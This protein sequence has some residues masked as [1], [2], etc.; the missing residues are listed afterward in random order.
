MRKGK[1][2]LWLLLLSALL[3][4]G[5]CGRQEEVDGS[6]AV[7]YA[8]AGSS[9][10]VL[11]NER[12]RLTLEENYSVMTIVDKNTGEKWSS[13]PTD[14]YFDAEA[15]NP[16][17]RMRTSSLFQLGYTNIA[18]GL[19][20][21]M[22]SPLLQMDY[23]AAGCLKDGQLYVS[24]D[25]VQPSIRM[26]LAFSL[27]E[28]GFRVRVPFDGIEEYGTQFSVVSLAVLPYMSGATDEAEGYYLYPDGSGAVME[29]QD[30]AHIG[31]SSRS[32][33]LY[34]D[35][36]DYDC[37]RLPFESETARA[38]LPVYGVNINDRGY[39]AI[40][41]Q[42][43]TDARI[44][45]SCSTK[46]VAING[47]YGEFLYRRGFADAR[48]KTSTVLSYAGGIIPGDREIYY[49]FLETGN[50]D[51]SAMAASYRG[52]L[53]SQGM[54]YGAEQVDY[55]LFLDILMG[56]EAEGLLFDEWRQ[57]TDFEQAAQMAT[58]LKEQGVENLLINLKGYTKHGYYSE[59]NSFRINSSLG[60]RA[61][62]KR[63]LKTAGELEVPVTLDYHMLYARKR[64]GGFSTQKD[65][66]YLG[67]YVALTDEE[68]ELYLLGPK[69]ALDKFGK[70]DG[71]AGEY[72]TAGY[73]LGGIGDTLAY[74][75]NTRSRSGAAET[76]AQWK[77]LLGGL[78]D[79]GRILTVEG[80]NAYV[81][82]YAD[83]LKDIPDRDLGF[84]FTTRSV[85]F[86]QLVVHGLAG[87][88]TEAGN[89]SGDLAGEKLKWVEYGYI[90]YFELT[91]EGS[92]DL[93]YTD[94]NELFTSEY[95][96]W[97]D[98]AV[99][100]Y[101]E[102]SES[103]GFLAGEVMEEHISLGKELYRVTYGDGTR[104]Y[105][106]YADFEQTA[107]GVTVPAGDYA[108]ITDSVER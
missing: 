43:D 9:D 67:N 78:S 77:E 12:Y 68:E 86:F 45:V 63:F 104:V 50:T 17:W 4:L 27:E 57:V 25:L 88:M 92:E 82:G 96:R 34:G 74:S 35:V 48:V 80:G 54:E 81:L 42:G 79:Q 73:S 44:T 58:E 95:G 99:R 5:G 53:E 32:Y 21:I 72:E 1:Y 56:I 51:Y 98:E 100:I 46:M 23:T 64:T 30:I 102:L 87:Y 70:F 38:M 75:Y 11:E 84:R 62:L 101:R 3:V 47:V 20:V 90:P 33:M 24:Y 97:R 93:M 107:D 6:A 89:L 65:I 55:P 18:A 36:Q 7:I 29:F 10:T 37:F 2:M 13:S 76:L 39:V 91:C 52:Y 41:T 85:P 19:G 22:N 16:M 60:G 105:V 14:E 83:Y 8:P 61:G 69:A 108:V 15:L 94:Y 28:D 49:R 40:L 59:P 26:T 106:N 103:I 66:V 31:A 71:K